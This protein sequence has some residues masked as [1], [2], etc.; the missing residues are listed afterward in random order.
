MP[1]TNN[2]AY[3]DPVIEVLK[4]ATRQAAGLFADGTLVTC[5]KFRQLVLSL[6]PQFSD[7]TTE[8]ISYLEQPDEL[9]FILVFVS[10]AEILYRC[11]VYL[12]PITRAG[13]SQFVPVRLMVERAS[14]A[15]Q[16]YFSN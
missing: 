14:D 3:Q 11:L 7:M 12:M 6:E 13:T 10:H 15:E 4:L 2:K 5:E 16:Y 9:P 1:Q 8:Q